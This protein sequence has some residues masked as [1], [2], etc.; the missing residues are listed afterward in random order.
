LTVTT[1][2]CNTRYMATRREEL[3]EA[4]IGYLLDNGVSGLS[5]RPLAAAIGTSARLL[6]YHFGSRDKLVHA[7]LSAILQRVQETFLIMQS[8]TTLERALLQFWNFA[9]DKENEGTLRL[10]FEVHGLAPHHPEMFGDYTRNSLRSWR[11]LLVQKI[12]GRR[13]EEK[14]TLTI[15]VVDGLLL[16]YLATGDRA[17]NTRTLKGFIKTL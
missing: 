7:A 8:E 13:R 11:R 2:T 16:D 17:R 10:I 12:G 9:T 3:L 15:A 14:A 1:V 4:T 5:L 6:I